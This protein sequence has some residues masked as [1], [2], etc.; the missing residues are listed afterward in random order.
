MSPIFIKLLSLNSV[1][2]I[3]LFFNKFFEKIVPKF[4]IVSKVLPDFE[5]TIKQEL[6]IFFIFLKLLIK[7]TSKLSK[8]NIFFLFFFLKN[9]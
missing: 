5:I 8:K 2:I 7:F 3:N 1:I 4:A 6:F 9:E